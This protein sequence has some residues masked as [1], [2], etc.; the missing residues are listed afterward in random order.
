MGI[1]FLP[2]MDTPG[3]PSPGST[4]GLADMESTASFSKEAT[5]KIAELSPTSLEAIAKIAVQKI[6]AVNP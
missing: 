4:S 3:K 6:Q 5:E 1:V 2:T